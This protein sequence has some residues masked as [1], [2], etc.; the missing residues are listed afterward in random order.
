MST[1][2]LASKFFTITFLSLACGA[3]GTASA[4]GT[5]GLPPQE[6]AGLSITITDPGVREIATTDGFIALAGTAS[7]DSG[8]TA[9]SWSS[10]QGG[11]GQATGTDSWNTLP[12][13][14]K[15]GEN[16]IT[17]TATDRESSSVT[18]TIVVNR[19]SADKGSAT[20][21][22][23]SPTVREDGNPLSDL[24][25]YRIH[26]GRMSGIYD[27]E[28]KISNPGVMTYLFNNL[29]PGNW[30]FSVTAFDKDGVESDL[31]HEAHKHIM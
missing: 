22:W 25:G 9:V 18:D 1:H 5:S 26:Y 2:R 19:E 7:I 28:I 17:I 8:I 13:E 12:I 23:E 24:K 11:S 20:L 30:Y 29:S 27:Y 6:P 15:L 10:D 14:L 31:S 3:C 21:S 4:P 16:V